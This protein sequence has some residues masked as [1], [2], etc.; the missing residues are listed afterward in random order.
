MTAETKTSVD[1]LLTEAAIWHTR[2]DCGTAD[3]ID[4]EKWRDADPRHAAA[5][6]RVVGTAERVRE[7]RAPVHRLLEMKK[8]A[9]VSQSRRRFL[10]A[11]VGA[12]A[13]TS[14]GAGMFALFGGTRASAETAV[15]EHGVRKLP[16]GGQLDINT[17]SK[18]QWQFDKN[19]RA[20][21]LS[22]GEI[23]VVVPHDA[24]PFCLYAGGEKVLVA[25][26]RLNA[27]LRNEALDLL[28]LD[29]AC[30]VLG[31]KAN[32]PAR[33]SDKSIEVRAGE[34]VLTSANGT[35]VRTMAPNDIQFVASWQKGELIF[36][37]ETLGTAVDEYNR[38]LTRK[39]S[40]G[41]PSLQAIQL[42]GRFK[43]H[44]P[45]DFLASLHA[46]FGINVARMDDGSVV[47]TR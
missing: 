34:A 1:A 23:A 45:A 18:V 32:G 21:W 33:E 9:Q 20:V 39:I 8:E 44:D 4:F 37:G 26:G 25:A 13:A 47:L 12:V 29:G 46:G 35:R 2:M 6:A 31:Q 16:D 19:E 7:Q 10:V 3:V 5:F 38:Y 24:R 28:I 27:R 30:M 36:R 22:R 42:G 40:I 14:M 43:T 17:N 11:G 41:D 15:G